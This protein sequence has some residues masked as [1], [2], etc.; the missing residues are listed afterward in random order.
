MLG[1]MVGIGES[2]KSHILLEVALIDT[3]IS[4]S[5]ETQLEGVYFNMLND[6]LFTRLRR[7]ISFADDDF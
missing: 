3:G 5:R 2:L 4:E 7:R 6:Y 1:A